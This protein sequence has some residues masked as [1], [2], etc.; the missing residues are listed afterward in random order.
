MG[1]RLTYP[2]MFSA[3]TKVHIFPGLPHGFY[4]FEQLPATKRWEEVMRESIRWAGVNE[5]DWFVEV[6]PQQP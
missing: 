6:S 4:A 5:G 2:Y 1:I 3:K